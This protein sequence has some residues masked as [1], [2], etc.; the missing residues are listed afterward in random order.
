MFLIFLSFTSRLWTLGP[1]VV[2]LSTSIVRKN[3][4]QSL[5]VKVYHFLSEIC[6]CWR[7]EFCVFS[8]DKGR[9]GVRAGVTVV[10]SLVTKN[11]KGLEVEKDP[12]KGPFFEWTS[13]QNLIPKRKGKNIFSEGN[14]LIFTTILHNDNFLFPNQLETIKSAVDPFWKPPSFY[15]YINAC[16][17]APG[18]MRAVWPFIILYIYAVWLI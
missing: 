10:F 1:V 4:V 12:G 18:S 8:T 15:F 17:Y 3:S 13:F 6:V 7:I 11:V 16:I 5:T 14:Y 9:R 2:Q